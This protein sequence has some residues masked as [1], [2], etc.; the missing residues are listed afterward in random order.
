MPTWR[1]AGGKQEEG[2]SNKMREQKLGEG[3]RRRLACGSILT[4]THRKVSSEGDQIQ[5][6][7]E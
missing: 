1:R 4:Y 3:E 2:E 5:S 6:E 7:V